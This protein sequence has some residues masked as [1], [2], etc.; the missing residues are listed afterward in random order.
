M[1]KAHEYDVRIEWVNEEGTKEAVIL[2][3]EDPQDAAKAIS[4]VQGVPVRYRVLSGPDADWRQWFDVDD[5]SVYELTIERD[6]DEDD[7]EPWEG[8]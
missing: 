5:S 7:D 6:T 4:R 1:T 8:M 3:C 2:R